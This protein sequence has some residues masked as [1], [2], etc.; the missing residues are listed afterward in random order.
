MAI[1]PLSL[2]LG[3]VMELAVGFGGYCS[4]GE[5]AFYRRMRVWELDTSIGSLK[6]WKRIEYAMDRI[7]EL[8]LVESGAVVDI[9]GEEEDEGRR[10]I[11][12]HQVFRR[13]FSS[14]FL[15]VCDIPFLLK[16]KFEGSKEL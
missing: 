4:Y 9:R 5:S 3:Y 6:T 11:V 15:H 8:L 13:F 10:C 12:S 2:A 16:S 1:N 7:D 14:H